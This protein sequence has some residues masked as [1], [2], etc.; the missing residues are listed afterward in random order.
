MALILCLIPFNFTFIVELS[1]VGYCFAVTMEFLAFFQ[2]RIRKAKDTK[3]LRKIASLMLLLPTLFINLLIIC[4]A[5][6]ATYIYAV[7]M[8]VFGWVLIQ[9]SSI[10]KW[11]KLDNAEDANP[12]EDEVN[13]SHTTL[14]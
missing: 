11:M 9:A 10:W 14:I 2:L 5:S 12:S 4:S 8:L 6:Y 7:S 3:L 1:N 13:M